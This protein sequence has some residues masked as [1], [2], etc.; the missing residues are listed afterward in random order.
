MT[1]C[2]VADIPPDSLILPAFDKV[3]VKLW[4]WLVPV[5]LS[6]FFDQARHAGDRSP[7]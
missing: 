6:N 2:I 3:T 4:M 7:N 5:W 1:V